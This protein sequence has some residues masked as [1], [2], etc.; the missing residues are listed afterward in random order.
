MCFGNIDRREEKT[1]K[2]NYFGEYTSRERE[3]LLQKGSERE[4]LLK[5]FLLSY[6]IRIFASC[7]SHYIHTHLDPFNNF[8]LKC[9]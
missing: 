5:L 9:V 3:S 6:L 8:E 1:Y 7:T 2:S 4:Y